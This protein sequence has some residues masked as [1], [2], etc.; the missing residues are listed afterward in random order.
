MPNL[1]TMPPRAKGI[2]LDF[3]ERHGVA[4]A[5]LAGRCRKKK[6]FRVRMEI[7]KALDACGYSSLQ[8]GR[9]LNHD[10][11]TIIYYLGRGKKKASQ[12]KWRTPKVRHLRFIRLPL[13]KAATPKSPR[14]YAGF[15]VRETQFKRYC[16]ESA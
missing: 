15:D 16:H 7:A 12:P 5:D 2:I 3:A 11:T 13:P 10:H 14:P 6:V 1:P 4:V 9:F 8:I